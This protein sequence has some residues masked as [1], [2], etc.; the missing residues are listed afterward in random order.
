MMVWFHENFEWLTLCIGVGILYAVQN[1]ITRICKL[2]SPIAEAAQR[3]NR[4]N[5]E[6]Q[7]QAM[8]ADAR[9]MMSKES[10]KEHFGED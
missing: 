7:R 2:L 3:F 9:L 8:R 4:E 5:E 10:F 6:S 1:G